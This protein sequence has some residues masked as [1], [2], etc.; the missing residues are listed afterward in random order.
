MEKLD[1]K[2][3]VKR[4]DMLLEQ[5]KLSRNQFLKICKINSN[6]LNDLEKKG[7]SPSLDK[8][9][10]IANYFNISIDY[11]VFGR[12]NPT[13][14]LSDTIEINK[15]TT[16]EQELLKIYRHLDRK[17]KIKVNSFI[18]DELEYM[19]QDGDTPKAQ[20]SAKNY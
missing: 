16:D 3:L 19:E 15:I 8:I 10:S 14:D 13:S 7:I 20:N 18:Y 17:R 4:I 12:K 11:L 2:D 6:F 5:H 1:N 9:I